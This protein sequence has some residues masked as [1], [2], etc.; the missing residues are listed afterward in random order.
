M[1]NGGVDN[2]CRVGATVLEEVWERFVEN[3]DLVRFVGRDKKDQVRMSED[4]CDE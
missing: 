1:M 3:P 2:E 4:Y